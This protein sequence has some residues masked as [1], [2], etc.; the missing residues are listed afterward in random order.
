VTPPDPLQPW[1]KDPP[2]TP[3]EAAAADLLQEV[4]AMP[5]LSPEA[6][7][8]VERRLLDN[9]RRREASRRLP[10]F[11]ALRP[12]VLA[13]AL[14]LAMIIGGLSYVMTEHTRPGAPPPATLAL[15]S[16]EDGKMRAHGVANFGAPA[17]D[18]ELAPAPTAAPVPAAPPAQFAS[19]E[20]AQPP[21]DVAL[22]RRRDQ[23]LGGFSRA[24]ALGSLG[25]ARPASHHAM[26]PKEKKAAKGGYA[27]ADQSGDFFAAGPAAGGQ[28]AG[29]SVDKSI[30]EVASAAPE[31]PAEDL[32]MR[33]GAGAPMPMAL[34]PAPPPPASAPAGASAADAPSASKDELA[35]TEA[36]AP[37]AEHKRAA[38]ARAFATPP[39]VAAAPAD[40][41]EAQ[42][43]GRMRSSAEG[44][45]D[46]GEQLAREG[47]Y[48]DA[49][50]AFSPV[51]DS[52]GTSPLV[53]RALIGRAR[54]RLNLGQDDA[55]QR[56]LQLYLSQFPDGRFAPVARS[57]LR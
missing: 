10:L 31:K 36:P 55:G 41:S 20:W 35:E 25:A 45:V 16:A 4:R 52:G 24:G 53:E 32:T 13:G 49:I 57:L 7:A 54:C 48:R 56:D 1:K 3:D 44:E 26:A 21:P 33:N 6:L 40:D 15:G 39:P 47:R 42:A 30:G 27:G 51:A 14:A 18:A 19:R 37:P 43:T 8:R 22:D 17:K 38:P 29:L 2:K 34:A 12:P 46:R 23:A 5:T 9:V 28:G 50:K 11:A